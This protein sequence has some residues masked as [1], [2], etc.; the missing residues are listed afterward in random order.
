ME[1]KPDKIILNLVT[2]YL[3]ILSSVTSGRNVLIIIYA[4][5]F[6]MI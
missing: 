6:I 1:R 4:W 3:V 5:L 2:G